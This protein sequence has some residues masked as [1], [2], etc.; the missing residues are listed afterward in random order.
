MR[1][2]KLDMNLLA[3]LNTLLKTRNVSRAAEEMFIT[4]SAMSNALGRLRTFFDDPLLVPLGRRMELTPLANSLEEPLRDI[5]TRVESAML[6]RPHFDPATEDRTFTIVISDYSMAVIGPQLV[7]RVA[8]LA[9][10]IR[11][12]LWAQHTNPTQLLDRGEVDVLIVPE[13]L[14]AAHHASEILFVDDLVVLVADDGPY[15]G[16]QIT[17]E[18]FSTAPHVMTEPLIGQQSFASVAM[19]DAGIEP[20][21]TLSTYSFSA[22]P[23]FVRG[24]GQIALIQRRLADLAVRKGGLQILPPPLAFPPLRQSIRWHEHRSL[25]PGLVWLRQQLMACA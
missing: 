9:P 19:Q 11:L 7:R 6:M 22:I 13:V 4:Q 1:F 10:N 14:G 25:D 21:Y 16:T 17:L 15:A 5:M 3:V 20:K 2:N 8:A 18:Q 23:D 24:T 12:N